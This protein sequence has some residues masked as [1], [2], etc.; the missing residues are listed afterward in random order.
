MAEELI[1]KDPNVLQDYELRL[2]VADT[3]CSTDYVMAEYMN[4]LQEDSLAGILGP[5]CTETAKS[6]AAV[7]HHFNTIVVSYY[8]EVLNLPGNSNTFFRTLPQNTEMGSVCS[9]HLPVL[10]LKIFLTLPFLGE[11][12]NW[13][14]VIKERLWTKL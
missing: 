5:G 10:G 4:Y 8:S 11:V 6:L 14:C 12:S 1:N 13:S 7:A 2:Q 3:Q 9:V